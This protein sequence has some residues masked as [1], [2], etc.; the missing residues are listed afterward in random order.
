MEIDHILPESAGG[1]TTLDNLCLACVGCNT[2]KY[3]FQTGI[4]PATD[5][6]SALFNPRTQS[7]SD[8]FNWSNDATLV[9][10]LTATG[11]ATVER[12][13]LNRRDILAS[14]QLWVA[15]GWHPPIASS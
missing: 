3:N 8:H 4:D 7:W 14:R 6:E 10:G 1:A 5:K 9:V 15:A 11:R 12:L 13:R 2:F